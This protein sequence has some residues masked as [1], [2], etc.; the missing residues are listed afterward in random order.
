MVQATC[1][2]KERI[3]VGKKKSNAID[4]SLSFEESLAQLEEIVAKL[5]G[6]KLPL[7]DALA[8]YETG[9][10]RLKACYE[11]LQNAERRIEL[12]QSVD[13]G[14]RARTAPLEDADDE[15]LTEK[16]AARSRRRSARGTG[17]NGDRVDDD[18]SLF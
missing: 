15:D 8:A 14:G 7:S 9:V 6:G 11:I 1:V 5:E 4:D 10:Q 18:A 3:H 16:S 2:T 17:A 13:A 12:V